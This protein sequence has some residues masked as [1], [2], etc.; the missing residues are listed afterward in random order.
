VIITFAGFKSRCTRPRFSAAASARD[1]S[2]DLDHYRDF[3]RP[4]SPHALVQRFALD[5]FHCA[6]ALARLFANAEVI[7]RRHVWM[8]Q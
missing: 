7:Y 3:D 1:L 8:S 2:R 6:K 4:F 5:Q